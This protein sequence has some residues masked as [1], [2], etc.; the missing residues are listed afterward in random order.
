MKIFCF[1]K[2]NF[3]KSLIDT[4]KLHLNITLSQTTEIAA[5]AAMTPILPRNRTKS[6]TLLMAATRSTLL[7]MILNA[8]L[9]DGQKLLP[10]IAVII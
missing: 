9:A 1:N 2:E 6:P 4:I 3:K 10:S 5:V 7:V 8:R